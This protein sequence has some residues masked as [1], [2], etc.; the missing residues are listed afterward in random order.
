MKKLILIFTIADKE[1]MSKYFDGIYSSGDVQRNNWTMLHLCYKPSGDTYDIQFSSNDPDIIFINDTK[2]NSDLS[3][4]FNQL[5]KYAESTD[6]VYVVYHKTINKRSG[7]RFENTSINFT[8]KIVFIEQNH[9][10]GEIYEYLGDLSQSFNNSQDTYS[11]ILASIIN[12]II[13]T[14]KN[15]YL[16][17]KLELLHNCMTP[18]GAIEALSSKTLQKFVYNPKIT[19]FFENISKERDWRNIEEENILNIWRRLIIYPHIADILHA[20][21]NQSSMESKDQ[22]LKFIHEYIN[23]VD[24]EISSNWEEFIRWLTGIAEIDIDE[25]AYHMKKLEFAIREK[26]VQDK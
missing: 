3:V 10:S 20:F 15:K 25:Y 9:N 13:K 21:T 26:L 22:L 24:E 14:S 19:M 1:T 12:F 11:H 5:N 6:K 7:I 23:V 17:N 2:K 4:F 16:D 8:D 18:E